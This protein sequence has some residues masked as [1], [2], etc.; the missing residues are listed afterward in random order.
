MR[1]VSRLKDHIEG[2]PV[3]EG[4]PP[5][6]EIDDDEFEVLRESPELGEGKFKLEIC[7]SSPGFVP[8]SPVQDT[9]RIAAAKTTLIE[10][11]GSSVPS[12]PIIRT[13]PPTLSAY[14]TSMAIDFAH[15]T[16]E[17]SASMFAAIKCQDDRVG[18][19]GAR[20]D[21]VWE[22]WQNNWVFRQGSEVWGEYL[23]VMQRRAMLSTLR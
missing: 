2:V 1:D 17:T 19:R 15:T 12:T 8:V 9:D 6:E 11:D 23:D 22:H 18:E 7:T 3:V 21:W 10:P 4:E 5:L 13:Q 14:I 16:H 20:A